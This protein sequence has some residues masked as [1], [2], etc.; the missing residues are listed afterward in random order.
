MKIERVRPS[1]LQVTTSTHELAALIAAARWV[2]EG[3]EGRLAPGAVAQLR[4][5]LE[6]YDTASRAAATHERPSVMPD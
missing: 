1:V 2:V 4:S 5:V 3:A 6:S